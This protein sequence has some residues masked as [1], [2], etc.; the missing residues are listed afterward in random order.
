M[1]EQH[2]LRRK[3]TI[4]NKFITFMDS[5]IKRRKYSTKR[6]TKRDDGYNKRKRRGGK[7][8][9]SMKP[10][11]CSPLKD[12]IDDSCYTPSILNTIKDAY[13][14]NHKN[15][16]ITVTDT[17]QIWLE[18][19]NNLDC[20][21]EDCWL[22]QIKDAKLKKKI[23]RYVF[24]PDKP[25]EW[26]KNP[27]EWLSNFDIMNVLEQYELTY[28]NFDFIG[29]TP[30]DFDKIINNECVWEELCKFS[31]KRHIKNGKNKI[32]VIFNLDEHDES[33]SHWVS[34]FVDVDAHLIFYFDSAGSEIPSEI[35]KLVERIQKES[36]DEN[37]GEFIF[38]Q[39]AP[40]VHQNGNSECGVYSLFFIITMLTRRI[41]GLNREKEM[42]IDDLKQLFKSK[43]LSDEYIEKYRNIYFNG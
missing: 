11:N 35:K 21:K 3:K 36:I 32:G 17:K 22:N 37:L 38:E 12:K 15:N 1:E 24:A 18:L 23:D 8:N 42:S 43:R 16:Q 26:E 27:N 40:Y 6:Y 20:T 5:I 33:G 25:P 14:E 30:I 2:Q 28:K 10:M 41:N 19:K 34:L 39:N 9:I 13:N 31:I 29:P 4:K 7:S